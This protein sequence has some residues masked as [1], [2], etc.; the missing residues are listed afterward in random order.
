MD[1]EE[2]IQALKENQQRDIEIV[3]KKNSDYAADTDPFQN[4]RLVTH[5]RLTNVKTGMMVRISD[6]LQRT[7]N[8][9]RREAKVKEEKITDTLSDTRNYLNILQVWLQNNEQNPERPSNYFIDCYG[10]SDT[11][12]VLGLYA[13]GP[14]KTFTLEDIQLA[15][16]SSKVYLRLDELQKIVNVLY[17]QGYLEKTENGY[18]GKGCEKMQQLHEEYIEKLRK[19]FSKD[20]NGENENRIFLETQDLYGNEVKLYRVDNDDSSSHV[21]AEVDAHP[22][23]GTD[24][25]LVAQSRPTTGFFD[26]QEHIR[27]AIEEL[28]HDI[29]KNILNK[30]NEETK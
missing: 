17:E 24:N 12:R 21:E 25:M 20:E 3:K 22:F 6:K 1:R 2:F 9:L 10:E 8:L 11:N 15:L 27:E 26:K 16:N 18:T 19:H 5:M 30:T 23:D 29:G 4:F 28:I 13:T 7:A 14:E